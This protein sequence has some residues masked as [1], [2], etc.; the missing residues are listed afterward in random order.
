M[1]FLILFN[2]KTPLAHNEEIVQLML[3]STKNM[4]TEQGIVELFLVKFLVK[5]QLVAVLCESIAGPHQLIAAK[6]K[7]QPAQSNKRLTKKN[8]RPTDNFRF[9]LLT[10][11]SHSGNHN[12]MN[13]V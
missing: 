1:N 10:L 11:S 3:C 4:F 13:S 2:H 8:K 9:V 5:S 7:T 12:I 6:K